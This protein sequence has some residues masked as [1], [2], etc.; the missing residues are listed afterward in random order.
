MEVGEEAVREG[1]WTATCGAA[2]SSDEKAGGMPS[3]LSICTLAV[4][5]SPASCAPTEGQKG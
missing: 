5:A 1:G 4:H 3:T 2:P